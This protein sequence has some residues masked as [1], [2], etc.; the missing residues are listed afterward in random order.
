SKVAMTTGIMNLFSGSLGG[1][2]MCH[3]AGGL[4]AQV[5]FGARTGGAPIVMGCA[6]VV[7][8][9]LG[10]S[11]VDTLLELFPRAILGTLLFLAGLQLAGGARGAVDDK[12]DRLVMLATA[13]FAIWHV[14]VAFVFGVVA[15]AL[16]RRGWVRL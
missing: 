15:Y 16:V 2:P 1:V 11:C 3:G 8:A 4:A 9:L 10:S 14:G 6:L 7:L 12:L 5:R 13:A